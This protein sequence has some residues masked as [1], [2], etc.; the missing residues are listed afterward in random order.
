MPAGGLVMDRLRVDE[1]LGTLE[2][3]SAEIAARTWHRA[4]GYEVGLIAF[5]PRLSADPHE[6]CHADRDVLC[7]ALRGSGRLRL[8]GETIA[9]EAGT[10]YRVPAGT[11]HDF[12]ASGVDP[13]VLL[14]TLIA[15]AAP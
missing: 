13:L 12:A 5:Y 9:V 3:L 14:Y 6:I 1:A 8:D 4:P 7:H 15:V 10:L 2:P 11:P